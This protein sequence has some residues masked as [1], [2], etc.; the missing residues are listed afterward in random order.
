MNHDFD[1]DLIDQTFS[2][3]FC[4]FFY[5]FISLFLYFSISLFLFHEVD[6]S[7]SIKPFISEMNGQHLNIVI[8]YIYEIE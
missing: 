4:I 3:L 7:T 8:K 6:N 1:E 2:P 5:F